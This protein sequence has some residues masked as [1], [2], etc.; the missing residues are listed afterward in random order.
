MKGPQAYWKALATPEALLAQ[1]GVRPEEVEHVILSSLGGY[2][3]GNV[4]LFPNA[5]IHLSKQGWLEHL[6][7]TPPW[8][9]RRPGPIVAWLVAEAFDRVHLVDREAT[10]VPGV[11]AFETGGHHRS[12]LA[13]SVETNK[14]NAIIADSVFHYGNIEGGPVLG[15]TESVFECHAAYDRIRRE[16]AIVLPAHDPAVLERHPGGIIGR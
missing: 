8:P 10:V 4:R 2:A 7:P 3:A 11:S 16:A 13:V 9:R 1:A 6:V 12:S 15:I 14:G 5:Q